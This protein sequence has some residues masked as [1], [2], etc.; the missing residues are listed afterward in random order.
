MNKYDKQ[1]FKA[2]KEYHKAKSKHNKNKNSISFS[3]MKEKSKSYK[4]EVTRVRNKGNSD[5]VKKLRENRI[6]DPKSYWNMIKSEQVNKEIEPS[7]TA[8][9]EHFRGLLTEENDNNGR[10]IDYEIDI[11]SDIPILNNPI[12]TEEVKSCITKLKKTVNPLVLIKF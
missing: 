9:Y 2:R 4:K 5:I 3:I 1:C 8:F 12:T 6:K 11:E 7:L 10:A